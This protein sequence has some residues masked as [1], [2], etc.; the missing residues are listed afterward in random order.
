MKQKLQLLLPWMLIIFGVRCSSTMPLSPVPTNPTRIDTPTTVMP[1]ASPSRTLPLASP[2]P[3]A[4]ATRLRT[5]LPTMPLESSFGKEPMG[6]IPVPLPLDPETG[7]IVAQAKLD[8]AKRLTV[9]VSQIDL[10]RVESITWSD[11]SLGCP[12]PGMMYTQALV[13]GFLIILR[14]SGQTYEYH[15]GGNRSPFLCQSKP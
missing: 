12:Q 1:T 2:M 5:I 11:G 10:V 4:T 6:G 15:S 3:I 7:Q 13:D 8:L 9:T 14:M